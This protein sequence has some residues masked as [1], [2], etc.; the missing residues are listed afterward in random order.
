ME[1]ALVIKE[2][3]EWIPIRC[4]GVI[5]QNI[6]FDELNIS[7]WQAVSK[8]YYAMKNYYFIKRLKP[9]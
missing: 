8:L 9:K 1:L 2:G 7:S 3:N 5:Q 4:Q 6:D